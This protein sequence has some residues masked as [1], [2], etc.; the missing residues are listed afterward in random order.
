MKKLICTEPHVAKIA[1][2]EDR[3]LGSDE[4]RVKVDFASPKHGTEMAD[5]AGKTPFIDGKFDA[6]WQI[7]VER[8]KDEP[9]GIIYGD[10]PLGNMFVGHII[11]CGED[12]KEFKVGDR[13]SS[14]GPI[15]E[16]QIVKAVNNYKLRKMK[17]TDSALNAVCYDPAQFALGAIRDGNVRPGDDVA[18]FGLGAIG[19]IGV[20]IAAKL[21]ARVIAF[22]PIERRREV[23]LK[24]GAYAAFDSTKVDAGLKIKELTNKR[25]A[26]VIFE[27]SG[28]VYALQ[29]AF[30]GL[31]YGGTIAYGAFA[32]PFPAGLWLGEEA[33][34]NN[35][36]VVFTRACSEPNPDYPRWNR[37]R[38][39]DVCW[40]ML[41]N[42]Y[43]DCSD[44]IYPI[45]DFAQSDKAFCHYVDQHPEESIKLGV[46][47]NKENY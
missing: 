33:H 41:M 16:T 11:E 47:F 17:E 10:L 44:I 39:E 46:T 23:A 45:V 32:K 30:K 15:K 19:L 9:R 14:Y 20:Q 3:P 43:L 12:V 42:G 4:V 21:G 28:N 35:A 2:Y 24:C 18:V 25:G 7:F 22:D 31:A 37:K 36:K 5:F 38:I 6:E 34:F 29:S 27:S 1:E 13:V 26:D 8:G 40:D